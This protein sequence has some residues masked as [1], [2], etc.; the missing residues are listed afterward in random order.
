M[1][2]RGSALHPFGFVILPVGIGSLEYGIDPLVWAI[3]LGL[4]SFFDEGEG[5]I[6][7]A[8]PSPESVLFAHLVEAARSTG[9]RCPG[10]G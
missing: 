6:H 8:A 5:T 10:R 1:I 3:T 7:P 4:N 9:L 2:S